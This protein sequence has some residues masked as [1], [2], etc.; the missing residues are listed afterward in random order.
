MI[1]LR[2]NE[3]IACNILIF[4]EDKKWLVSTQ[5]QNYNTD[6]VLLTCKKKLSHNGLQQNPIYLQLSGWLFIFWREMMVVFTFLVLLG[7]HR[8][9]TKSFLQREVY[10]QWPLIMHNPCILF[11]VHALWPPKYLV[12]E[13]KS[14]LGRIQSLLLNFKS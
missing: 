9:G 11:S 14:V 2:D 8:V 13:R 10:L 3:P 12:V 6:S 4:V 1:L 5:S 7:K